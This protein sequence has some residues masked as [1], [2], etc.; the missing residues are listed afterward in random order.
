MTL[1]SLPPYLRP[2]RALLAAAALALTFVTVT[3]SDVSAQPKVRRPAARMI[4]SPSPRPVLA[5]AARCAARTSFVAASSAPSAAASGFELRVFELVNQE[6][7]ARGQEPLS[8]DAELTQLA[9]RHSENMARR[10]FLSHTDH[11]GLDAADRAA[12]GGVCGWRAI[13]ENIAYN[14]GYEDPAGFVVERWMQSVK[15]RENILRPMF[16]HA[17]IGV[18]RDADGRVYFTQVFVAR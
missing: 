1:A 13:A 12:L 14:Q 10:N 17:G 5:P 15:H 18:S 11:E 9:R 4:G 7:R 16:T 2:R 8:W 6:R 3:G